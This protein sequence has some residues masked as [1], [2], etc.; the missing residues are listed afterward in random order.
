[1][2]TNE[3]ETDITFTLSQSQDFSLS[4]SILRLSTAGEVEQDLTV[5]SQSQLLL[6]SQATNSPSIVPRCRPARTF[7]TRQNRMGGGADFPVVRHLENSPPMRPPNITEIANLLDNRLTSVASKLNQT[8][9]RRLVAFGHL[10]APEVIILNVGTIVVRLS[11]G[12]QPLKLCEILIRP[13][14]ALVTHEVFCPFCHHHSLLLWMPISSGPTL[15]YCSSQGHGSTVS[16]MLC[17]QICIQPLVWDP[18]V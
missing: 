2:E 11:P 14:E 16:A 15:L 18:G 9:R 8:G 13:D 7:L 17:F 1:M 6:D 10:S 4:D 5:D 3:I 12:I